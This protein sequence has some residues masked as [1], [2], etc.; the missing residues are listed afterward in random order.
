MPLL[1]L[2]AWDYIGLY[3]PCHLHGIAV[4][5]LTC[6]RIDEGEFLKLWSQ[7]THGLGGSHREEKHQVGSLPYTLNPHRSFL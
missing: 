2:P 3:G 5:P 6:T 1:A 7:P 4:V